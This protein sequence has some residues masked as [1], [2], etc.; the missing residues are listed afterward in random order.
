MSS[1]KRGPPT[2]GDPTA[3]PKRGRRRPA[4]EKDPPSGGVSIEG[5]DV[6]VGGDIAGRDIVKILV[7]LPAPAL[8]GALVLGLLLLVVTIGPALLA[9]FRGQPPMGAFFN[10]AVAEF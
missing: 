6:H 8:Y 2:P 7:N 5:S 4:A 1:P 9:H 3:A 10:I